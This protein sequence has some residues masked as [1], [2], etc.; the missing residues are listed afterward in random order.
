MRV[1]KTCYFLFLLGCSIPL[2]GLKLRSSMYRINIFQFWWAI[3]EPETNNTFGILS[4]PKHLKIVSCIKV[5][6]LSV[7]HSRPLML[8]DLLIERW[9]WE[10]SDFAICHI[11]RH[12]NVWQKNTI[13]LHCWISHSKGILNGIYVAVAYTRFSHYRV[14]PGDRIRRP[15]QPN[16]KRG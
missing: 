15:E 7:F 13:G 11:V 1:K 2:K 16:W 9:W 5:M 4:Q 14:A 12:G 6:V 10:N 3:P 8:L